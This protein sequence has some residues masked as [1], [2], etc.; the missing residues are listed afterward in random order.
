MDWWNSEKLAL[1][2]ALAPQIEW[3]HVVLDLFVASLY[4]RLGHLSFPT[5]L[6]QTL[7]WHGQS[8]YDA[9]LLHSYWLFHRSQQNMSQT[10]SLTWAISW[11]SLLLFCLCGSGYLGYEI[12]RHWLLQRAKVFLILDVFLQCAQENIPSMWG[13]LHSSAGLSRRRDLACCLE[14]LCILHNHSFWL[15]YSLTGRARRSQCI[16]SKTVQFLPA[17]HFSLLLW[18]HDILPCGEIGLHHLMIEHQ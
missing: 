13:I 3:F 6:L 5:W 15:P 17:P 2:A 18:M 10:Q 14:Q 7:L 12:W 8:G 16:A 9:G 11:L 4:V 1:F